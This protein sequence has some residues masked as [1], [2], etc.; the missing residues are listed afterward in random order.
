MVSNDGDGDD[1]DDHKNENKTLTIL[2]LPP[3]NSLHSFGDV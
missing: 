3:L 2:S 1:G